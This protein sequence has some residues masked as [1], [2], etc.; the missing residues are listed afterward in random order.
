MGEIPDARAFEREHDPPMTT[1]TPTHTHTPTP[2]RRLALIRRG[3]E[4]YDEARR[5][6]NGMID[7]HPAA[8]A[9]CADASQVVAAL[10]HARDNGMDVCVKGGGHGAAG[11]AAIDDALMIDLSPM[12]A[13]SVDP[14][15]GRA[16]V[17]GGALWASVDAE[18]QRF[19]LAVT[20]GR[21]STTGV[22]GFTLGSGSGWLERKLGLAA[23]NLIQATVV[24]AD[25]RIVVASAREHPDLFWGL[26][27]GGGNFGV[28]TEFEFA[29]SP[30]GPVVLAGMLLYPFDRATEIVSGY[31]AWIEGCPDDM[32]GG[33]ALIT[34]PPAPFVP[35]K[36]QGRHALGIVVLHIGA[37]EEGRQLLDGFRDRH[38]PAADLVEP[39][40]YT[41]VQKMQDEAYPPGARDYFSAGFFD[42]LTDGAI[43]A[44]V[45]RARVAPSPLTSLIL[46]PLGGA[47]ARVGEHDTALGHRRAK[48]AYQ[49]LGLW[50]EPGDDAANINWVRQTRDAL[51]DTARAAGFPNFVAE[52]D[53]DAVRANYG[54]ERYARLADVKRRYDPG[55]VFRHNHNIRPEGR[56]AANLTTEPRP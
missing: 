19:G 36:L 34:A 24:L 5:I 4:G 17:G 21:V 27:G 15:L 9:R 48:W 53:H 39:M 49:A 22:G 16:R 26:R 3:D 51:A 55:N 11:F 47:I 45:A 52:V 13:V 54:L 28:V 10:G 30:V 6:F 50:T 56:L 38:I 42:E 40:P 32:C 37:I 35:E 8:I 31:R 1:N 20:G 18:T 29:L 7:R 41:A 25:G 2:S 46:Q 43:D 14:V 12:R 44:L 23:D 33:I